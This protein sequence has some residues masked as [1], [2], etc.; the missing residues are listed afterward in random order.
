MLQDSK[1]PPNQ[2]K[3]KENVAASITTDSK[4][5]PS[6]K[7]AT[8]SNQEVSRMTVW[9]D[10]KEIERQKAQKPAPLKR[11]E[12]IILSASDPQPVKQAFLDVVTS[13]WQQIS[14]ESKINLSNLFI[15]QTCKSDYV[16]YLTTPAAELTDAILSLSMIERLQVIFKVI[17]ENN[18]VFDI[19]QLKTADEIFNCLEGIDDV[20][21]IRLLKPTSGV[22]LLLSESARHCVK[23]QR[24]W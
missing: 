22:K 17:Q 13:G 18:A 9:R 14:Y 1:E 19:N 5:N 3:E 4:L 10:S 15:T 12:N 7:S 20:D 23:T 24:K 11:L 6:G 16:T 2:I 8:D 21:S